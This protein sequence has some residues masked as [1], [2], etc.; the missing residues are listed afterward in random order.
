MTADLALLRLLQLADS[1]FPSGAYTLSHGLETMAAEGLIRGEDQLAGFIHVSLVSKFARSDLVSLAAAHRVAAHLAAAASADATI[2]VDAVERIV[3]IDRRL[4]ASKLAADDRAGS[5][6]V[7][8]RLATEASRLAPSTALSVFLAAI[9]DGRATG[10]AAVAFGLS[11]QAFGVAGRE[12]ALAAS[13]AFVLGI[14]TAAVRLGL[15]GHG[16][17]QRIVAD[18]GPAIVSAVEEA[19]AGDWRRLRPS[20]PQVEIALALHET[21][22]SR[23]F[24]S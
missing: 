11:G 16:T 1:G 17:A 15:I 8:R 23:Q 9:G 22:P 10:N 19:L 7:G 21:A 3:A 14:A 2:E 6:R 18:A 4:T 24:A 12:T 20:A 13:F 5:A